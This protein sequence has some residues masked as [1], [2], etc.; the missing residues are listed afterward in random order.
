MFFRKKDDKYLE[1]TND[2]LIVFDHDK[3]TS[4]VQRVTDVDEESVTVMGMYKVPIQDCEITNGVEGRNFFYRAPSESVQEVKR[5]AQ[6]ERSM[7]L[8]QITSY[9][10]PQQDQIDFMK[11]GLMAIIAIAFIMFGL[12]S[13][14]GGG[15]A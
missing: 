5:L 11:I 3:K 15:G 7:V 1:E 8:Q 13:C 6:L 9:K 4:D 12:S 14:G 10:P 2:L